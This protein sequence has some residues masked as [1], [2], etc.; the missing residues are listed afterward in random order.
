MTTVGVKPAEYWD[1]IIAELTVT[2]ESVRAE[3]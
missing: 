3:A 2:R 1:A